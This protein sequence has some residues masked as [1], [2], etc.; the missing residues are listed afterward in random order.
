MKNK[1]LIS[2]EDV[3]SPSWL[4][5]AEDFIGEVLEKRGHDNWELSVLFCSDKRI[6]SLNSD[7][8][9]IDAPTDV[10]SFEMGG[11]YTDEDGKERYAAGDIAI[12]LEFLQK[13]AADFNVCS[14]EELKR[15]LIHGILHLEG[16]DHGENHIGDAEYGEMLALQENILTD[17]TSYVIIEE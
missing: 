9:G 3:D 17:F 4:N 13:N 1:L 5:R 7:F 11:L 15:L 10:L 6:R 8:R 12:S 2:V 14:N 16:M